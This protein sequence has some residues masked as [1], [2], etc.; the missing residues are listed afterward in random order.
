MPAQRDWTRQAV[1][2][3]FFGSRSGRKERYA[4]LLVAA[5]EPDRAPE[6]MLAVLRRV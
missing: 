6:P 4:A 3:R 2:R 5:L 1:L